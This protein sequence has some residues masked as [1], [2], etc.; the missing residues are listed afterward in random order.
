M[1]QVQVLAQVRTIIREKLNQ[2]GSLADSVPGEAILIRDG[3]FCGRRFYS[4][5]LEA[6]W[7]IEENQVKFYDRDGGILEVLGLT[8]DSLTTASPL[9]KAA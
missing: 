1:D 4:D 2:L 5:G 7:F 9:R 3:F 6:V 8:T